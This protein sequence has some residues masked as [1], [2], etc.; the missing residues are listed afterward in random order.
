MDRMIGYNKL[1][2]GCGGVRKVGFINV[3]VRRDSQADMFVD[4]T[5]VPW[6]WED[7][8]I[9]R[10]ESYHMLEHLGWKAGSDFL[11]ECVR[12]LAPGG[13][14]VLELP[15]LEGV[16]RELLG[17][18]LSR[19]WNLY[20]LQRNEF[21]YHKSGYTR[22]ALADALLHRGLTIEHVGPG[23]DYHAKEEPCQRIVA[24]KPR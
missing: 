9:G 17:G 7:D 12:V 18:N 22:E 15:D 8:S 3:D 14:L 1:H 11:D 4:L 13:R 10:I 5:K 2:L 21:D 20:G 24:V 6:P 19:L 16:C 23:T